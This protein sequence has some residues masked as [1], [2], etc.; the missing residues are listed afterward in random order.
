MMLMNKKF[1]CINEKTSSARRR[2]VMR[3]IFSTVIVAMAAVI[4][5]MAVPADHAGATIQGLTGNSFNLT[6]NTGHITTGEGNSVFIW[7][8]GASAD[9]VQYP[10]PTLIVTEGQQITVTLENNLFVPS[11]IIFPGQTGVVATGGSPGLLTREAGPSG[12]GTV[13]YTFTASNPGTYMYQSGTQSD[14]QVEMGLF[15]ALIVRPADFN[16][17]APKAY[18]HANTSYDNEYLFLLSEMDLRWHLLASFGLTEDIDTSDYKPVYWFVNGRTFPHTIDDP[19]AS[20]LP[21]QP[22]NSFVFMHP[23]DRVLLRIIG[24][25]RDLH[26][27]HIHGNNVLTIA[28]NGRVLSSD[29][30]P[31]SGPPEPDIARSEY[32]V[33][34]VPGQTVDTIF[35]W[36]GKGLGWDIYGTGPDYAHTCSDPACLDVSPVDGFNDSNGD[37][38]YDEITSEYCPDH[39][40]PVPVVLP[41]LQAV[42]YGEAYSGSPF[43]GDSGPVPAGH[44]SINPPAFGAYMFPWHSHHE[45]EIV[46]ND[47]FIGGMLSVLYIVPHSVNIPF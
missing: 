37:A 23:G 18:G 32:T 30:S 2:T 35:T 24:G 28:R 25:G 39:G 11:S 31:L 17:A 42:T 38:C 46:N 3:K 6:A 36:T 4:I 20:W 7:G 5:V 29:P 13:T 16:P 27:F 47:V 1:I 21:N 15:G 10:G 43:L 41:S 19:G 8:Y 34:S 44:V 22:Y 33:T 45:K 26:P 40:K 12:M 9:A 14:L